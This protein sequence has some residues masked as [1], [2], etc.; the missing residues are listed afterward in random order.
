MLNRT[1]L[2]RHAKLVDEMA[3]KLGLDLEE[4]AMRGEVRI[5]QIEDAVL[6]CTNCANPDGCEH[7]LA[8]ASGPADTAPDYCRNSEFFRD[9]KA[10]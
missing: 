6:R 3:G 10:V 9:L 7:W 8:T 5:G 4:S 2:K 1:T